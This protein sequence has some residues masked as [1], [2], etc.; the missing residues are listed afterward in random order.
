MFR[1]KLLAVLTV[2]AMAILISACAAPEAKTSYQGQ[3]TDSSGAPVT[4]GDYQMTFRLYNADDAAVGNSLWRETQTVPVSDGLFNVTLGATEQI[5]TALFAQQLW[6]GVEV[7]GDGEM[8]PRQQLTGA[9]YAMSLVAGAGI[10]GA[11]NK[12]DPL[13]SSLNVANIGNGYGIG[14]N[15]TGKAGVA[16]D[17]AFSG[18]P[19]GQNGL[20]LD[21]FLHGA[22]IT[23]TDG[24]AV[25]ADASGG[26]ANDEYGLRA[27]SELGDGVFGWG[28]GP[29][30]GDTGVTGRGQNGY[31]VY[32][33]S[34]DGQWGF[35]TPDDLFVGGNCTGCSLRYVAYNASGVTLRPGDTVSALGVDVLQGMN[36]PVIKIAPTTAGETVWGVVVGHVEMFLVETGVDDAQPGAH[37]GSV[38][39]QVAPGEYLTV[40]VEGPAQ[41]RAG[42]AAI[43]AGDLVYQAT[44]GVSTEAAGPAIGVALDGVDAEGLVWVLVGLH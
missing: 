33:F 23:S 22:V 7:E 24:T 26:T 13:P 4:D 34:S 44:T 25:L 8:T 29:D 19:T 32:G 20:L 38:G 12:D 37:F 9:P 28:L 15:A 21:N 10:Q 39:G 18:V 30:G 41:I 36:T 17:G 16:I 42:E 35:Y 43:T 1:P 40:V 14:V 6:L 3:L 27:G 31:G 2:I 5:T 11:I